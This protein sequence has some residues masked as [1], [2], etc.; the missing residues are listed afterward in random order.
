[1]SMIAIKFKVSAVTMPFQTPRYL[2]YLPLAYYLIRMK[3][4]PKP[5]LLPPAY[6]PLPPGK[7]L[8]TILTPSA[9]N[10]N[11]RLKEPP[12]RKKM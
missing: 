7:S 11:R 12:E 4:A 9:K 8:P 6:S 1:M 3:T 2:F 10:R 5:G